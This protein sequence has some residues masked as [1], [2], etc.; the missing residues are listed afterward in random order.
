[1]TGFLMAA[2]MVLFGEVPFL[3][4][5]EQPSGLTRVA[6]VNLVLAAA[7]V[8]AARHDYYRQRRR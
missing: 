2:A 8:L 6:W 7:L 1:M 3:L 5:I 4:S